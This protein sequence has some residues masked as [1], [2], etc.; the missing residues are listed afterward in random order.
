MAERGS[1]VPVAVL[2][3]IFALGL[4][5]ACGTRV[6]TLYEKVIGSPGY[7]RITRDHT[8]ARE[9]HDGLEVRFILKATWLSPRWVRAFSEEYSNIYYLDGERRD[10][11]VSRWR[12][13][14][15]S[16]VRFFVALFTPE[17]EGNDLDREGT[18]W[19][20]HLV[21]ADEVEFRPAYVRKSS[22]RP[23][24]VDRFFPYS[25]VWYRSYEVA[26]PKEAGDPVESKLGSSR[27]KLVLSGVRGRAVLVW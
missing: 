27:F 23:E 9:V 24:E 2:A 13:E 5:P 19:S 22:L 3:M 25:G 21:R 14:S 26:F 20:L 18:L 12:T 16:H 15:E 7:D 17:E 4:A 6:S 1:P 10:R 11:V 8:Q